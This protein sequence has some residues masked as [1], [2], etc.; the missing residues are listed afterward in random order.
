[1]IKK[2]LISIFLLIFICNF[3]FANEKKFGLGVILGEPTGIS[4][5]LWQ[6]KNIAYDGA[7]AWSTENKNDVL[8]IHADVLMH[9]YNFIEVEKGKLPVYFGIGGRIK[10]EDDNRLGARFLIE[11]KKQK[12]SKRKRNI[13]PLI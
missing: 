8:H 6:E 7:V 2:S 10:F 3:S 9:M 5:K 13:I 1:M 11:Y 4:L 12:L